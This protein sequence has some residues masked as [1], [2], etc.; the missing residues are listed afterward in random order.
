MRKAMDV[1]NFLLELFKFDEERLT[2][3]KLNKLLYYAQGCSYQRYGKPI[4]SD[5][6]EAWQYGPVIPDVYK[7]F[8]PCGKN[9]IQDFDAVYD[10]TDDEKDL[11][12]DVAREYGRFSG[13]GLVTMTHKKGTPWEITYKPQEKNIIIPKE[14]I[15]KYFRGEESNLPTLNLE[16]DENDYI[17]YRDDDGYLVL[18]KEYDE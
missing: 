1:A 11:L 18:P 16:F 15:A 10:M 6:I 9:P 2:N 13:S 8:Q 4:F 7:K 14:L 12:I 3:L 5:E 17:G